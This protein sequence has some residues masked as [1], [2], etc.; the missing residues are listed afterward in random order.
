MNCKW[1]TCIGWPYK[2]MAIHNRHMGIAWTRKLEPNKLRTLFLN[3]W[4]KEN[5]IFSKVVTSFWVK[6]VPFWMGHT[7]GTRG[8]PITYFCIGHHQHNSSSHWDKTNVYGAQVIQFNI[9]PKNLNNM[10]QNFHLH[11]CKD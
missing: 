5:L 8:L 7:V 11:I 1:T 2:V 4:W 6:L 3:R 9:V 10:E